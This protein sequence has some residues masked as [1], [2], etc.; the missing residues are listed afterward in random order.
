MDNSA[1]S[2]QMYSTDIKYTVLVDDG[3]TQLTGAEIKRR[4]FHDV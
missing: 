1:E 2:T 4:S 3:Q